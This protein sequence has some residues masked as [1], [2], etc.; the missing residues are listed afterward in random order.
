M[1]RQDAG[2]GNQVL[3]LLAAEEPFPR[4]G[5]NGNAVTFKGLLIAPE[6]CS[7]RSQEGDI[8][9][10]T[11]PLLP[12]R[13]ILDQ[14]TSDQAVTQV[15]DSIRLG[16]AL[17]VRTRFVLGRCYRH[18]ESRHAGAPVVI[19]MKGVQ[20]R[21]A[22]LSGSLENVLEALVHIGQD[23]G[24]GSE[25]GGNR[26]DVL[27]RLGPDRIT[28]AQVGRNVGTPEAID[29]LLGIP[30][31]EQGPGPQDKAFPF[32]IGLPGRRVAAQAPEDFGLERVGILN[33]STSTWA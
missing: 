20:P 1:I 13:V 3:N 33:S 9:R 23:R 11:K 28:R 18:V 29:G 32:C 12:S 16:I 7:T 24:A 30:D 15:G 5:R 17:L 6:V 21:E 27:D 22:G 25:V 10:P 8:T 4:L 26:E 19:E 2:Q 31:Q 14:L